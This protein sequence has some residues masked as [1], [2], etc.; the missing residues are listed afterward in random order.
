MNAIELVSHEKINRKRFLRVFPGI[1]ALFVAGALLFTAC[2]K[3]E[4]G[5]GGGGKAEKAVKGQAEYEKGLAAF[6]KTEFDDAMNLFK[7]AADKGNTDAQIMIG[8]CCFL[9]KGVDRDREEAAK[10]L[11]KARESEDPFAMT[12]YGLIM[13]QDKEERLSLLKKAADKGCL[14]AQFMMTEELVDDDEKRA[15]YFRKVAEHSLT[16]KKTQLDYLVPIREDSDMGRMVDDKNMPRGDREI[17]FAQHELT[18]L[19][20]EGR[21]VKKNPKEARKWFEKAKK[22]GLSRENQ[23]RLLKMIEEA[24]AEEKAQSG[25]GIGKS[26]SKGAAEYKKGVAAVEDRDFKAAAKA[27]KEAADKGNPGAMMMYGTCLCDGKGVDRDRTEGLEWIKKAADTGDAS[28]QAI[29]G[30]T[31]MAQNKLDEAIRYLKKSADQN[32]PMG[33]VTLAGAY[34]SQSGS[35]SPSKKKEIMNLMKKAA[36]R[37]L[38]SGKDILDDINELSPMLGVL[39]SSGMDIKLPKDKQT[40][41]NH[42]IVLAQASYGLACAREKDFAEARKMRISPNRRRFSFCSIIA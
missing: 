37:S 36:D 30:A 1:L 11:L 33:Q 18:F 35:L 19:Y 12:V 13:V 8:M 17:V 40:V 34:M 4:E 29:Y 32:C 21:G 5:G 9:G 3:S 14:D 20:A 15:E 38:S 27:F 39:S 26:S 10:W 25:F 31:L 2:N 7:T 41:S 6:E 23:E 22:N 24:E 28:I 16:G 42:I